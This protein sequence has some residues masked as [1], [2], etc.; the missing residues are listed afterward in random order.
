MVERIKQ[1]TEEELDKIVANHGSFA[2]IK[3]VIRT[4][5]ARYVFRKTERKPLIVPVVMDE[6]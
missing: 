4:Q 2:D 1:I 6:K 3:N 5:V